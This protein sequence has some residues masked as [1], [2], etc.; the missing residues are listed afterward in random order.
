[1]AKMKTDELTK[2]A[3]DL[4][5]KT[6]DQLDD[7]SKSLM[8][9]SG[10]DKLK[11]DKVKLMTDRDKLF[12]RLGEQTYALIEKGKVKMPQPLLDTYERIRKLMDR[13]LGV[14]KAPAKKKPAKKVT[15]KVVKKPTKR[16]PAKKK[17]S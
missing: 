7:I 12:R 10:L 11:F 16:K 14:K 9:S 13:I 2:Q 8:K 5:K 4:W 1:M 6:V 15:K 17:T 3:L